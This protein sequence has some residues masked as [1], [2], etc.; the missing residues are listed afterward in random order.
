MLRAT[1]AL[2][3][4]RQSQRDADKNLFASY[5]E[6]ARALRTS[7]RPGQ[8]FESLA[9]VR[10]ATELARAL[11]LPREKFDPLRDAALAAPALPDL[12]PTG[13]WNPWPAEAAPGRFA[14]AH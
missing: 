1:E 8:R 7:R 12:Y 9:V 6:Q 3:A 11:E 10:R 13:P 2:G 4:A 14:Q 5:Q